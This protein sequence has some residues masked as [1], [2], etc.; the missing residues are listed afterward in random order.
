[1]KIRQFFFILIF[2]NLA[3]LGCNNKK[4][5]SG[6]IIKDTTTTLISTNK[7][8]RRTGAIRVLELVKVY[9]DTS[10]DRSKIDYTERK[11]EPYLSFSDFPAKAELKGKAAKINY[12]SNKTSKRYRTVINRVIENNGAEF[13]GVYAFARWGAV[14]LVSNLL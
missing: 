12:N 2:L 4:A 10:I 1:M 3:L 9:G 6:N 13:G 8:E 7:T 5:S 14:H 11:S